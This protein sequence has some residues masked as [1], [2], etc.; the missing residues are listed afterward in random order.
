[1]IVVRGAK[2]GDARGV[3]QVHAATWKDRYQGLLESAYLGRLTE[4]RLLPRWRSAIDEL[5]R[6]RDEAIF[7]ATLRDR[8]IGFVSTGASRDAFSPWD[9]EITMI[10]I[11]REYCGAGIGRALMK[12]AADHSIRRGLFSVGLWVLRDNDGAR[13][14]YEKLGGELAGR[15]TDTVGG[16]AAPLVCYD[17]REAS[18]LAERTPPQVYLRER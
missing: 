14:F 6:D 5:G 12:A 18:V 15:K 7:V 8:V 4:A 2:P 13:S 1:M 16:S 3:A 17:W 11:L 9:A 10:Y